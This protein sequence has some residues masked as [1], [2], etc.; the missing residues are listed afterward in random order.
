[1]AD[2]SLRGLRILVI[3]DEYLLANALEGRL[4][5]LGCEVLGPVGSLDE[6]LALIRSEAPFDGAIVD[7]N[8][9]RAMA[10]PAADMLMGHG[11]P[12]LFTTGYDDSM[13]PDRFGSILRLK[14]PFDIGR[15]VQALG[16]AP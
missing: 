8:L 11:I 1:M 9:G 2:P 14:K 13:I 16:R 3:E 15:I 10:Y 6:A 7:I 5:D 12:F 4:Q